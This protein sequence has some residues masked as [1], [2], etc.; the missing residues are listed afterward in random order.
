MAFKIPKDKK[1]LMMELPPDE[2]NGKVIPVMGKIPKFMPILMNTWMK[3]C[4][5]MPIEINLPIWSSAEKT[6]DKILT[7]RKKYK[8]ISTMPPI[9]PNDSTRVAKIKSV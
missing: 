5:K 4:K 6:M 9:K 8:K 7:N 2:T 3:I 1:V